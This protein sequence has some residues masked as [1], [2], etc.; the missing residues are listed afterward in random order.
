M[1]KKTLIGLSIAVTICLGFCYQDN[2]FEKLKERLSNYYTINLQLKVHLFLNQPSYVPG[3][4]A[5]IKV[6]LISTA[7]KTFF[8]PSTIV[9]INLVDDNGHLIQHRKARI[10][11][12]KGFSE[13]ALPRSIQPGTYSLVAYTDWMRNHDCSFYAF[14]EIKIEG[15]YKFVQRA[16]DYNFDYYPEGG[17]LVEE[18]TN[19]VVF[20][21]NPLERINISTDTGVSFPEIKL[22]ENGIGV[23][24]LT[25][26]KGVR[27]TALYQ[28]QEKEL[29]IE[30]DGIGILT[31]ISVSDTSARCIL[32]VP[33]NSVLR[34]E[35]VYFTWVAG[36]QLYYNATLDFRKRPQG[37]VSIPSKHVP[38]GLSLITVFNSNEEILAQRLI[39]IQ[40]NEVKIEI[41]TNKEM[42]NVRE[43]VTLTIKGAAAKS[44][45]WITVYNM[46]LFDS[47]DIINYENQARQT[48]LNLPFNGKN[49]PEKVRGAANFNELNDYLITQK[50][51]EFSWNVLLNSDSENQFS[52]TQDIVLRGH[53]AFT[54]SKKLPDSTRITFLL[55]NDAMV[56]HTYLD[57]NGR[58]DLPLLMDL[59]GEEEIFYKVDSRNTELQDVS[60]TMASD[61][62]SV[63]SKKAIERQSNLSKYFLFAEN[64]AQL[65]STYKIGTPFKVGGESSMEMSPLENEVIVD[66]TIKLKDY[67][68]FQTMEE[69]LLEIIPYLRYQKKGGRGVVKLWLSDNTLSSHPPLYIIDGILTDNTDY[70]MKLLPK[71]IVSIKVVRNLEELHRF[72]IFGQNGIIIVETNLINNK[73]HVPKAQNAF[74]F[75]GLVSPRAHIGMPTELLQKRIPALH[76]TLYFNPDLVTDE[77]GNASLTF[78]SADNTGTF[79][80][81]IQ[82][83]DSEGKSFSTSRDIEV[84]FKGN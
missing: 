37:I 9:N 4:T 55:K 49:I 24:Y 84:R 11:G 63:F 28:T 57:E 26:L 7:T 2:F 41:S 38:K 40:E 10:N 32:Q 47:M 39:H 35:P 45:G 1:S 81:Y 30:R 46:D 56:Y 62:F 19:K 53:V 31:T 14:Y 76:S 50:W 61:T 29:K 12:G 15:E 77:N 60:V 64:K 78:Y 20:T 51:G 22:N 66:A 44:F 65:N 54:N 18:I 17:N 83:Y 73:Q 71:N 82:G 59:Y 68:Q 6:D 3:D 13:F 42:Y 74:L 5:L 33:E 36:G 67:V 70:F 25:P 69:V 72:G 34:S 43:Q 80:I 48:T 79:R 16:H 23:L 58:F 75:E 27:Y 8:Q 52:F 21:G